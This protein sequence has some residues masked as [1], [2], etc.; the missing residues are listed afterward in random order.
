MGTNLVLSIVQKNVERIF[1]YT[2][3]SCFCDCYSNLFDG[4]QKGT[5]I[6]P[7]IYHIQIES[8]SVITPCVGLNILYPYKRVLLQP[9]SKTLLLTM[10]GLMFC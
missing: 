8:K 7:A 4:R 1:T 3:L 2:I 9:R 6:L 10:R 5:E